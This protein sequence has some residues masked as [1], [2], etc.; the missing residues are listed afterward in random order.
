MHMGFF[1]ELKKRGLVENSTPKIEKVFEKTTTLYLGIDPTADSLHLGHFLPLSILKRALDAGNKII[2]IMGGGTALIGDPSGKE[3]ERPILPKKTIEKNKRKLTKQISKFFTIDNRK[4]KIIDNANWLENISLIRF[5]RDIGKISSVNSMLDLEFVRKRIENQEFLSFAEF[6]Y[7]LLQAYD[8]Y[9]LF[10]KYA[11][12]VQV[13]G[14]DQWGNI[15]QGIELIKRKTGKT[16]HGLA[17]PLIIDPSTGKKFGKTATGKPIWLDKEKTS[18]FELYQFLINISDE[19]AQK[20]LYYY[21]FKTLEE[22]KTLISKAL[23]SPEARLIQTQLAIELVTLIHGEETAFSCQ[24]ASEILFRKNLEKINEKDFKILTKVLK[25]YPLPQKATLE[26]VLITTKLASSKK[27][28]KRLIK[29]NA[30][31]TRRILS[32]ILIRKGKKSFAIGKFE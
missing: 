17:F 3:K 9:M 24:K 18:P 16:A 6:T 12:E 28:A 29:E 30:I 19:L 27:Q 21:S 2:I 23:Q 11:C 7:Q 32:Y 20:L 15:I 4:V 25:V 1:D 13:G 14:S 8:F 31:K 10:E 5:L 22:I 26:D